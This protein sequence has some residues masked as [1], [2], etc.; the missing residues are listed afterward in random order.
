MK[1]YTLYLEKDNDQ[2]EVELRL[3][4]EGVLA[5]K[6]KYNEMTVETI[7]GAI[8][9]PEKM[10]FIFDKC[11]NFP[12]N[13]NVIKN[14]KDLYNLLVDNGKGGMEGFWEVISGIAKESGILSERMSE[15]MNKNATEMFD[16]MFSEDSQGNPETP[17]P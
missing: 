9:D 5:L 16:R 13:K 15:R 10:V 6:K 1:S 8:E 2:V 3:D 7:Y 11:L 4:I 12:G 14:G 17:Q